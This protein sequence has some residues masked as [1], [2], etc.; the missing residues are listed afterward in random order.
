VDRRSCTFRPAGQSGQCNSVDRLRL[1]NNSTPRQPLPTSPCQ[2]RDVA[3]QSDHARAMRIQLGRPTLLRNHSSE[4]SRTVRR[5]RR[6]KQLHTRMGFSGTQSFQFLQLIIPWPRLQMRP[7]DKST[8]RTREFKRRALDRR[9]SAAFLQRQ[10]SQ[11]A[12]A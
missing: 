6:Y 5:K 10:A 11:T 7:R 9:Q 1:I 2:R 8:N 3:G 12:T 4:W